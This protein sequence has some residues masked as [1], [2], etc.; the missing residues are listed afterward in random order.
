MIFRQLSKIILLNR[1]AQELL[2]HSYVRTKMIYPL[3]RTVKE[4]D[5]D[6]E[7][8]RDPRVGTTHNQFFN[9][10]SAFQLDDQGYAVVLFKP[11]GIVVLAT[12]FPADNELNRFIHSAL[13][14][15]NQVG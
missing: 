8:T 5:R 1:I 14:I 12:K 4:A 10:S 2:G 7:L 13:G 15:D 11:N 6:P 9:P 3:C